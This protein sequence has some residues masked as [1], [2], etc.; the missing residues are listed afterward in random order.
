[1]RREMVSFT[2]PLRERHGRNAMLLGALVVVLGGCG[3]GNGQSTLDPQAKPARDIATLWWWMLLV[4]GIVL[5]GALAMLAIGWVRRNREGIPFFGV[6]EGRA[7]ALVVAFGIVIP[8]VV[9]VSVFVSANFVVAKATDA[10]VTG[11]TAMT[12]HVIG[13]QWW[14][15]V[16]YPGGKAVTANEI[17]IPVGRRVNVVATTADV[18]HS[19]WV[20]ELNRKIDTIPGQ[21]NHVLLLAEHAGRYRGQ[22]AEFCGMQHAHMG[23]IVVADSVSDFKT[24]ATA[25]L[26]PAKPP[27]DSLT[28]LGQRMFVG[29]PC[30]LC[31]TVRG[32]P[33]L[34]TVGP[35]LTHI[36]SRHTIAA[37]V[38]PNTLGSIEGWIAN[39]QAI[40][41]GALMPPNTQFT[42][43]ELRAL[44]T[45]VSSLK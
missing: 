39:A 17:H 10:P 11:S 3:G 28:L 18:I 40:K 16:R 5:G 21:S 26:L 34:G 20:P 41:P 22:C 2:S 19:F 43:R 8:L 9:N 23:L 42:G 35:D 4:A 24:W 31:H 27:Q 25:Q 45:Y 12:I 32:T 14:W 7:R 30:A 15:E 38:M 44:A 13:R 33:A 36:G 6:S 37:G 29:G 1:M